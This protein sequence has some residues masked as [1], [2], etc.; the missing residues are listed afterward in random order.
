MQYFYHPAPVPAE[1]ILD[2][3]QSRHAVRVLR[4][5]DGE[6]I[7]V[8]DGQGTVY[9]GT[10]AG[11]SPTA[12]RVEVSDPVKAAP[13]PCRLTVGIAPPKNPERLEWFLEKATEMGIDRVVP[14]LCARSERRVLKVERERKVV[15]S[16]MKQSTGAWLP[17]VDE[18]TPFAKFIPQAQGTKLVGWCDPGVE[19]LTPLQ[20]IVPGEE[21]TILIGPEGDFSPDEL[22]TALDAG[23]KPITLGPNRLRTETAALMAVAMVAGINIG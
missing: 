16:A 11:A 17:V 4:L 9:T 12:C 7:A 14:L 10:I 21:I 8:G 22:K 20:A 2:A 18:L 13:R 1:I 19:K 23:F 15:L 5:A 6:R 3:D